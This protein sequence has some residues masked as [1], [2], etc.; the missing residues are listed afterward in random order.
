MSLEQKIKELLAEVTS[1]NQEQV[2]EAE[3]AGADNAKIKAGLSKKLEAPA[4]VNGAAV[5]AAANGKGDGKEGAAG[6]DNSKI[7]A[8]KKRKLEDVETEDE[9]IAEKKIEIDIDDD[10]KEDDK[11]DDKEEK[12]DAEDSDESED[13]GDEDE[14]ED[15]DEK[16]F[17]F[18][19]HIDALTSGEDL[20]E[21]FKVKAATIFEA[22]VAAGVESEMQRLEE[23]YSNALDEAV[24]EIR[25]NLIENIDGFLNVV[26]ENWMQQNELALEHGIKNEVLENFVDG[27]KN[28]FKESYIEVP[29]DKL[30]ILDEQA[31]QIESMNAK[32]EESN[33]MIAELGK[34]VVDLTKTRIQESVGDSLTDTEFEKF[35]SLCESVEFTSD[36]EYEEKV[37]TI[38]ESYFP[39]NK[40]ET[41][42][43]VTDSPVPVNMTEGVMSKYVEA[44]GSS[45]T[46]KR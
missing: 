43:P 20:S 1:S 38:K 22:A 33:V 32:L 35:A 28:L 24:T 29:E 18:K 27:L 34:M 23:E 45:L 3:N 17:K 46:F 26:V 25:D 40:R 42:V 30:N 14:K 10:K 5:T 2:T 11:A 13:E 37:Q 6:A 12:V 44:L 19:E 8:G 4:Q 36:E 31:E 21:E 39:K 16:K 7:E 41:S 15:S 9:V